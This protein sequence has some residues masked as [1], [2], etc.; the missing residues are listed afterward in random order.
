MGAYCSCD[1]ISCGNAKK[2]GSDMQGYSS[3]SDDGLAKFK[4][5]M[6]KSFS[7]P[8]DAFLYLDRDGDYLVTRE[9][10]L[11]AL[12]DAGKSVGWDAET[13]A[14]MRRSGETFFR[15]MD[16][17]GN[18]ELTFKEFKD[19]LT[20]KLEEG[21]QDS[22]QGSS[23]SKEFDALA[24]LKSILKHGFKDPK[25]A[26]RALDKNGDSV[27]TPTELR[28]W[29]RDVGTVCEC[30]SE[31]IEKLSSSALDIFTAMDANEDGKISKEEF[32]VRLA[33]KLS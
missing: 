14:M 24:K 28:D 4:E 8:K 13:M 19:N 7:N 20:K 15:Q 33:A 16:S 26:F 25:E 22:K 5:V 21:K 2:N 18:G 32:K 12:E 6:K 31:T 23:Q 1:S 3:S 9:E 10:W 29:L 17:N 27:V 11:A 30:D